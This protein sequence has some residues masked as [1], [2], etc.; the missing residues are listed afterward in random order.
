MIVVAGNHGDEYEGQ[1]IVM[2]LMRTLKH[3]D[4]QGHIVLLSAL[5]APAVYAGKRTSPYDGGNLNRVFPGRPDGGPTEAIAHFVETILLP[6][7]AL[8]VDLHSGGSSLEYIP[9]AIIVNS[10][11]AGRL[12]ERIALL[13][14]FGLPVSFVTDAPTGGDRSLAGACERAGGIPCLSTELGGGGTVSIPAL[15]LAKEAT[16]RVLRHVG[17]IHSIQDEKE[18]QPTALYRRGP[19]SQFVFAPCGGVFEPFVRLGD[20]VE[21]GCDAGAIH[22]PSEPWAPPRQICF[23][24]SGLVLCRRF[25]AR[26]AP[27]DCLF[28]VGVPFSEADQ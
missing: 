2:N 18:P 17:S 19:F 14:V 4:V 28:S 21:R 16:L 24:H 25:T 8:V 15:R 13:R 10:S 5:N 9:S 12:R 26:T 11:E 6:G 22:N 1:I 27:G 23:D 20:F 7:A 3:Q